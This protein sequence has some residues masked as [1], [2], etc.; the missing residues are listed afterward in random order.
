MAGQRKEVPKQVREQI[1]REYKKVCALC[2]DTYPDLHHIDEDPSNN[3][4]LNLIPLC[5]NCHRQQHIPA[6][7]IDPNIL[8]IF[9][10][11]KHGWLLAPN[12]VPLHRRMQFLKKV[13]EYDDVEE[14]Q[15]DVDELIR[16][17]RILDKGE[18]YADKI[19]GIAYSDHPK[20]I[21]YVL[22]ETAEE[23]ARRLIRREQQHAA[24]R[25]NL[26]ERRDEIINLVVELTHF[27][28]W[29]DRTDYFRSD[30]GSRRGP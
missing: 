2:G 4:P 12:F 17:V 14:L 9:R 3:D 20:H 22:T 13:E 27:Q 11:Y 7:Q 29:E 30:A 19:S 10:R 16:F 6:R 24:Y 21:V 1:E 28:N 8:A 26:E 5:G 18:Y 25:A 15:S 23:R